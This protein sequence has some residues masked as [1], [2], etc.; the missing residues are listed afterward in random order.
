MLVWKHQSVFVCVPL[1][2]SSAPVVTLKGM[3]NTDQT[4]VTVVQSALA[5]RATPKSKEL[6]LA[7]LSFLAQVHVW[8]FLE[9]RGDN[10][11]GGV[12]DEEDEGGEV[13]VGRGGET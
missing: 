11:F 9:V 12:E 6:I 13:V 5:K 10:G 1:Q 2:S 3:N 4:K 8:E 7:F